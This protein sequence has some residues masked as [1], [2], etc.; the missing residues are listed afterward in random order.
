MRT[1][2]VAFFLLFGASLLRMHHP[3]TFREEWLAISAV[4][5]E[6]VFF[7]AEVWIAYLALEPFVR[8][9]W[10]ETLIGWNRLLAGRWRDPMVGREVL[11]GGVAG[12]TFAILTVIAVLIP[13]WVGHDVSPLRGQPVALGSPRFAVSLVL[14][15][16]FE[17]VFKCVFALVLLLVLRAIVRRNDVAIA[18]AAAVIAVYYIAQIPGP[19]ML[20]A[21]IGVVHGALLYFVLLRVGLLALVVTGFVSVTAGRVPLTLDPSRFY[22]GQSMFVLVLLAALCCLGFFISL[23]GK[24]FLPRVA[25]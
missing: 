18:L 14:F 19:P 9:R 10:P 24:R 16:A 6:A 17:S 7:A 15:A 11:V 22:F 21:I 3:A 4:L 25:M 1:A 20:R 5:S 23:A 13:M 8:R 2:L 12:A